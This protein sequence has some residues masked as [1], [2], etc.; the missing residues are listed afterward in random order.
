M[1]ELKL[2]IISHR[3]KTTGKVTEQFFKLA[4]L[5]GISEKQSAK[6]FKAITSSKEKVL[7]LIKL[8]YLDDKTKRNYSQGYRTKLKKLL[9]D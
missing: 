9:R 2:Y 5:A 6:A 8:S 1:V 4:E 7:A 3:D